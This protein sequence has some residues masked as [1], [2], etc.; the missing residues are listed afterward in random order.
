MNIDD[1]V[2]SWK[3]HW[4]SSAE[5]I[6]NSSPKYLELV[7]VVEQLI[8]QDA[9]MLISGRADIT[10]RMIVARLAHAHGLAPINTI[11]YSP[12]TTKLVDE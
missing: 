7:A 12:P 1:E 11:Y 3:T 8:R 6:T 4:T 5:G 9:H 10:A 2:D